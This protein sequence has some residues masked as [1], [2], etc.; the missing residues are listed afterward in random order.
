MRLVELLE[1]HIFREET[2]LFPAAHQLLG[3]DAW[4]TIATSSDNPQFADGN[5]AHTDAHHYDHDHSSQADDTRHRVGPP[6]G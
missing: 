5:N 1:G 4:A 3:S 2:D 6:A